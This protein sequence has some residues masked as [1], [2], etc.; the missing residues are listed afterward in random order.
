MTN[1][2][3]EKASEI[4]ETEFLFVK[5]TPNTKMWFNKMPSR[6]PAIYPSN[7]LKTPEDF[8]PVVGYA[9]HFRLSHYGIEGVLHAPRKY[10]RY[11]HYVTYDMKNQPR[12]PFWV[13]L[14]R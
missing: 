4:I 3:L 8:E 11:K 10:H 2:W 1:Y 9:S 13:V 12:E 5:A 6:I 14:H 7:E